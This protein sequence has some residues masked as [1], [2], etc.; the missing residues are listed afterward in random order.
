MRHRTARV[1]DHFDLRPAADAARRDRQHTGADIQGLRAHRRG[2]R[3]DT[4]LTALAFL[5]DDD[6]WEPN[7]LE[8]GLQAADASNA[9]VVFCNFFRFDEYGG[10]ADS[11]RPPRPPLTAK[12]AMTIKIC[13]AGFSA[14][15]LKRSAMRA[16][17]GC[18]EALGSTDWDLWIRL[19]WRFN[20]VWADARLVWIRGHA[21]N[22]SKQVGWAYWTLRIQYKALTTLPAELRHIR[23][24]ILLEMLK[25]VMRSSEFQLRHKVLK[26][27]R[28]P[29][30]V[31]RGPL[32]PPIPAPAATGLPAGGKS[33]T[34]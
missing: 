16:V 14:A 22:T 19:S 11:T 15:M 6:L 18:D 21:H 5:D 33:P 20:L 9:D 12:E 31:R 17:G 29:K 2:Q 25:V 32:K 4:A 27:F 1:G 8:V 23:P 30:P 26:H 28:R 24:R 13:A 7:R 34:S 10:V 3:P